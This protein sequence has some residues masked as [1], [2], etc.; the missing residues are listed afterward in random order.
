MV[1]VVIIMSGRGW[2]RRGAVR[3]VVVV[4]S[5]SIIPVVAGAVIVMMAVVARTVIMSVIARTVIVVIS[6]MVASA[7]GHVSRAI[8]LISEIS[9]TGIVPRTGARRMTGISRRTRGCTGTRSR[10]ILRLLGA[11]AILLM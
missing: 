4:A 11:T 1:V 8:V 9:G 2:R 3:A 6:V 5:V 7:L 10:S